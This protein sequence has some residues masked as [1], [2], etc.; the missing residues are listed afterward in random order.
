MLEIRFPFVSETARIDC[1]SG[2]VGRKN[3]KQVMFLWLHN[4]KA[5][6]PEISVL[7]ERCKNKTKRSE[8]SVEL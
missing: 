4:A 7:T 3:I 1:E 6:T 8:A 5:A 2:F